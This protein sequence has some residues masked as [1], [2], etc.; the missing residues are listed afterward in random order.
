MPTTRM[1]STARGES[2][3]PESIA[4]QVEAVAGSNGSLGALVREALTVIN[5]ALDAH[6]Y[7]VCTVASRFAQ[8]SDN[9]DSNMCP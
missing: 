8:R 4:T 5:Q 2:F 3:D 6:G 7:V 9:V 1:E